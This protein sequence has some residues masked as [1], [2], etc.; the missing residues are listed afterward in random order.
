MGKTGH[1]CDETIVFWR[2]YFSIMVTIQALA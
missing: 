1:A 2:G